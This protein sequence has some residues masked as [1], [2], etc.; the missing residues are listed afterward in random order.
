MPIINE[1][2]NE[3]FYAGSHPVLTVLGTAGANIVKGDI[4]VRN[5]ALQFVPWDGADPTKVVGIAIEPSVAGSACN[6][7][8]QGEVFQHKVNFTSAYNTIDKRRAVFD[9]T[10][11]SLV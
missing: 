2:V 9:F 7:L 1:Y 5:A 6:V 8:K 11:I 3:D 10:A 4:L